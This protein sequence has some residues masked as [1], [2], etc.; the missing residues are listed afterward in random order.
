[1]LEDG[2]A[3]AQLEVR[4][5]PSDFFCIFFPEKLGSRIFWDSEQFFLVDFLE[6]PSMNHVPGTFGKVFCLDFPE[7]ISLF[8]FRP[9]KQSW[10]KVWWV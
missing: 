3:A 1:V 4:V 2:A 10:L 7:W 5:T 8:R 9:T 6:K